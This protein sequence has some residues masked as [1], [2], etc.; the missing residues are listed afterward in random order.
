MRRVGL[1]VVLAFGL[2][3]SQAQTDSSL[4]DLLSRYRAEPG[5][6]G[7]CEQIGIAYTRT[8]QLEQ[9]ADYF[10]K[11]TSLNPR[12]VS[13]RKNLATVSWFLNRKSE[14]ERLFAELEKAIPNDPVPQLYLGLAAYDRNDYAQAA[15]HFERAGSLAD[16]NPELLPVVIDTYL[17]ARK[18][19]RAARILE[20]R[21][22]SADAS[23]QLYRWLAQVYDG[24]QLPEKAYRAYSAAIEKE[25][26]VEENY[27][28]LAAFAI[29]HA[30]LSFARDVLT[31][32]LHQKPGSAKL[33]FESGLTWALDGDFERA[34]KS[35]LDASAADDRWPLP[36]LALG[37]VEMQTGNPDAA[38]DHFRR[39]KEIAPDDYRCYYLHA[40]A[41]NR[42]AAHGDAE[43]RTKIIS[44]LHH[45]LAINPKEPRALAD[46]A[47]AEIEAGDATAAESNLRTALRLNPREPTALYRL[48][49]LCRR[50][51]K[52]A[53]AERLTRLFQQS[54]QKTNDAQNE[55]ILILKTVDSTS[56]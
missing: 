50:Q 29:E 4:P 24:Q 34:R 39:A 49:L 26:G 28:G 35:F 17:S 27:L 53:E 55:F 12:S 32:G 18:F 5:N 1:A 9:A 22:T 30:N 52:T 42:S 45:A 23:S 38:A 44:E 41:L 51:G 11:A 25:P 48:A 31:R 46:L 16:D 13:S 7:I 43:T 56:R 37:V 54:K 8:G 36:L 6:A 2:G 14:A 3:V 33:L 19:E 21:T 10:R 47:Q 40:L 20:A 15:S